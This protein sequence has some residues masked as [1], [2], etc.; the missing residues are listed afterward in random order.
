MRAAIRP[1]TL[2]VFAL[3]ALAVSLSE[4]DQPPAKA[5]QRIRAV[6]HV[7]FG[8]T[9]RQGH[10]LKNVENVLKEVRG[11]ADVEVVCHGAGLPLL[12]KKQSK[13]ADKV[14][15]LIKRGVRFAACENTMRDKSVTKDELIDG[16]MTVP[17]GAVE[18]IRKQHAGFAYFKP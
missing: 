9:E 5:G 11:A 13:H 16:V 6:V 10:G 18:I 14:Q 12:V 8:D 1:R 17:S 15:Q 3:A 4:A 7:N 2:L